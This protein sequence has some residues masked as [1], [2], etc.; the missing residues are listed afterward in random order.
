MTSRNILRPE[1]KQIEFFGVS[2]SGKSYLRHLIKKKYRNKRYIYSYKEIVIKYLAK[3]EK[4][5]FKKFLLKIYLII[6]FYKLRN[7][8]YKLE[9][10]DLKISNKSNQQSN[11][12]V[13]LK[14]R[15]ILQNIYIKNLE[16]IYQKYERQEFKRYVHK[17]IKNS[18]FSENNKLVFRRWF[19]EEITAI[20]LIK[21]NL[22]LID[23]II[24]SEGLIQRLFIYTYKKKN[25]KT[26]IK[27]YLKFCPLPDKIYIT[28]LK[29]FKVKNFDNPE[30]NL[31]FEEQKKIYKEVLK[32]IK[33][34][35]LIQ[36]VNLKNYKKILI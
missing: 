7:N 8:L 29:R 32:N 16:R 12:S 13:N 35:E 22:T 17:L 14:I 34:L 10:I 2:G 18:N 31:D 27:K 4:N 30:F 28:S 20:Y 25:K 36:M 33:K 23:Y 26:I 15:K 6:K 1:M 11:N 3:E 19:L 24:D 9:K 5:I 21:K